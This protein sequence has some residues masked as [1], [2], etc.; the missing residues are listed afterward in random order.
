MQQSQ[1]WNMKT[2]STHDALALSQRIK[3]L[4]AGQGPD[5]QGIALADLV[6]TFFAGHHPAVREEAIKV[7]I[8]CVRD[9]IPKNEKEIFP[10]GKPDGWEEQ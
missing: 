5:L 1:R 6:A 2:P 9:L 4:L 8:E 7:W 10:H 3:P